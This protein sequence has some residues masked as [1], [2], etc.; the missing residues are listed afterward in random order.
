MIV[1]AAES[2]ALGWILGDDTREFL[3]ERKSIVKAESTAD[4][5]LKPKLIDALE[6]YCIAVLWK[7]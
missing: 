5:N 4:S 3:N 6:T 2:A 7:G 1:S